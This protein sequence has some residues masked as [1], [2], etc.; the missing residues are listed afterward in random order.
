MA[1]HCILKN[2]GKKTL[3]TLKAITYLG[4]FEILFDVAIA[5][6]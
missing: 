1:V 4:S 5:R 6:F 2:K 3:G